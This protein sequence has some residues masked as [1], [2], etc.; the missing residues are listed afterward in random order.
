MHLQI[1]SQLLVSF[2]PEGIAGRF[3]RPEPLVR[4]C[5]EVVMAGGAPLDGAIAG[6]DQEFTRSLERVTQ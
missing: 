4:D 3:R 2:S 1:H 6:P 5:L